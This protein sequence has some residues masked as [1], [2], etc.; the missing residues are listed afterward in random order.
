M[1]YSKESLKKKLLE[2]HCE[3][4]QGNFSLDLEFD[5]KYNSWAITF[6]KGGHRRHA[7]I[8][9]DDADECMMGKQCIYLWGIMDQYASILEEE[10]TLSKK[11]DSEAGQKSL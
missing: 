4:N 1:N 8:H 10:M 7:L 6:S 3:I 2:I 5:E 11:G 9:K